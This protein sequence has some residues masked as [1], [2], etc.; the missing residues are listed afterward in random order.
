MRKNKYSIWSLRNIFEL[1][2]KSAN[3]VCLLSVCSSFTRA[4]RCF[5]KEE[6]LNTAVCKG[7]GIFI[8]GCHPFLQQR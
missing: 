6:A 8:R 1:W 7:Q 3:I 2:K 5:E 4:L